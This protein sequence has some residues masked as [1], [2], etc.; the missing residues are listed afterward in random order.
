M[1]F[2]VITFITPAFGN[3][4]NVI[5]LQIRS[6]KLFSLNLS[7]NWPITIP[8]KNIEKAYTVTLS[9][10]EFCGWGSQVDVDRRILVMCPGPYCSGIIY[11]LYRQWI[12]VTV[13]S[14]ITLQVVYVTIK[15]ETVANHFHGSTFFSLV[16]QGYVPSAF[17]RSPPFW[18]SMIYEMKCTLTGLYQGPIKSLNY[19]PAKK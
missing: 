14:V 2:I 9:R 6:T 7:T 11:R 16:L 15:I 13:F 3:K 18:V 1:I 19:M 5:Y 17:H 10:L 8:W 4:Y 12:A